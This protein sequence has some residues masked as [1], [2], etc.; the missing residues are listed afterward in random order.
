MSASDETSSDM[1]F[2]RFVEPALYR[3]ISTST[4]AI[5]SEIVKSVV[6]VAVVADDFEPHRILF[7]ALLLLLKHFA[8][9]VSPWSVS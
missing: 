2:I 1:E 7:Q 5:G 3:V 8:V 6:M 9:H 4:R